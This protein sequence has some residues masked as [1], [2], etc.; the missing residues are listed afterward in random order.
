MKVHLATLKDHLLDLRMLSLTFKKRLVSFPNYLLGFVG[1]ESQM[2][3]D[4][5]P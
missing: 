4:S 5:K 1:L 3:K 2:F